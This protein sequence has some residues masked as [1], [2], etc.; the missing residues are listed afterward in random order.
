VGL[1]VEETVVA[2]SEKSGVKIKNINN[3]NAPI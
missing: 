1:S 2:F 3:I